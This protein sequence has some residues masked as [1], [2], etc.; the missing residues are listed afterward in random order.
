[1]DNK[2]QE[3]LEAA[4]FRRPG[5]GRHGRVVSIEEAFE[6]PMNTSSLSLSPSTIV[7]LVAVC[8]AWA[9]AAILLVLLKTGLAWR[10][11]TDIPNDR[12]LHV[13]PTPRVGGWGI[14]PVVVAAPASVES[15]GFVVSS[16]LARALAAALRLSERPRRLASSTPATAIALAAFST[17]STRASQPRP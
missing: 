15:G 6:P 10:L 13:R 11:A 4:V 14:V 5:P 17:W 8:A 2:T 7:A 16:A 9:S 3:A 12:S 1:M